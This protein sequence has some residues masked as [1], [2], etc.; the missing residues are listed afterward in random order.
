MQHNQVFQKDSAPSSSAQSSA[1]FSDVVHYF[2]D[3]IEEKE[4]AIKKMFTQRDDVQPQISG[5]G[6]RKHSQRM[7]NRG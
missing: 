7:N 4:A 2:F 1:R 5:S 6:I 3:F